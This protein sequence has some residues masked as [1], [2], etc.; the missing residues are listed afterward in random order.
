LEEQDEEKRAQLLQ[1]HA[2]QMR[3]HMNQL[4]AKSY[5][6]HLKPTPEFVV[7]FIP[8]ETFFSAALTQDPALLEEGV[9]KRVIPASPT[10]LIALLR[11][12]A[13][14]W[15]QEKMAES[16]EEVSRTGRE[17]YDRVITFI[18][19]L[20]KV[21]RG[22]NS[23]VDAYNKAIGSLE[24]RVLVSVRRFKELGAGSAKDVKHLDGVEKSTRM[25]QIDEGSTAENGE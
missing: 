12:V 10:T 3:T 21:G 1:Q 25:L 4:A 16:A 7:M 13:Y 6:D 24:S 8:G 18:E 22:L 14:G 19:H 11:A 15:Q 17:L 5:W 20:E 2:R 9:D 23:S